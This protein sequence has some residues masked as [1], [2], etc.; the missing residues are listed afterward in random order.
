MSF[1]KAMQSLK[2]HHNETFPVKKKLFKTIY[3]FLLL[4]S[5]PK[6]E[7]ILTKKRTHDSKIK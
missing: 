4:K 5:S 2:N 7:L 6:K 1:L 3:I